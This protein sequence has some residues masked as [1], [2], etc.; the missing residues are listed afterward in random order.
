MREITFKVNFKDQSRNFNEFMHKNMDT[1]K[2]LLKK[3]P[4][5]L[6]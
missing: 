6:Q 5:H 1:F 4:D 3:P 2:V